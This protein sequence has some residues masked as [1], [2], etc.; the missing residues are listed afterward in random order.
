LLK[1]EKCEYVTLTP[2]S[3]LDL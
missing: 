3:L 2:K 1:T